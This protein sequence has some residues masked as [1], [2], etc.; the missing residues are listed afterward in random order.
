MLPVLKGTTLK[1]T[2]SDIEA[3][4]IA[5]A[6]IKRVTECAPFRAEFQALAP[7]STLTQLTL[8][9]TTLGIDNL[10]ETMD[11]QLPYYNLRGQRITHPTTPGIYIQG[12]RKV[13]VK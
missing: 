5:G 2:F 10:R 4:T 12:G 6:G 9:D 13:I 1:E 3:Y 11:T 8:D 7:A